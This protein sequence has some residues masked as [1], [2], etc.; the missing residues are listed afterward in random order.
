MNKQSLKNKRKL[1]PNIP[2]DSE[3]NLIVY[4]KNK[5][6]STKRREEC[7]TGTFMKKDHSGEGRNLGSYKQYSFGDSI[8]NFDSKID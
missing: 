2:T 8:E 5:I 1:N 3:G 4:A 6:S 7:I